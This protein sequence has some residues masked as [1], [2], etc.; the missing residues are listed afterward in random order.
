[1]N[2]ESNDKR[3]PMPAL[4]LKALKGSI[5][6]W[7]EIVRSTRAED[8]AT[9]NCPLCEV[10]LNQE[11]GVCPG[12]PVSTKTRNALCLGTP[13]IAWVSHTDTHKFYFNRHRKPGC[14]ECL[15]LVKAE[16]AFL[17][18]LLPKKRVVNRPRK[19]VK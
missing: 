16:L 11:A 10:F 12:C 17:R 3:K 15:R 5:A 18:S 2:S 1:M 19:S 13:Y 7:R 4:T 6:K 8:R 9:E 14:K